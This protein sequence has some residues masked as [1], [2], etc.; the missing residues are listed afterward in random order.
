M[1]DENRIE[2]ATGVLVDFTRHSSKF[3]DKLVEEA[4]ADWMVAEPPHSRTNWASVHRAVQ[5][6]T[7]PTAAWAIA[8]TVSGGAWAQSKVAKIASKREFLGRAPPACSRACKLCAHPE[9]TVE[10]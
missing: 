1:L 9:G 6:V 5:K 4:T 8:A 7:D 3:V 2:T 10:H